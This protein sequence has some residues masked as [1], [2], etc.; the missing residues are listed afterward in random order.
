MPTVFI[1]DGGYS[2]YLHEIV[3]IGSVLWGFGT[4][5]DSSG[6]GSFNFPAAAKSTDGGATWALQN[7]A[8]APSNIDGS[9]ATG[10]FSLQVGQSGGIVTSNYNANT[11]L[12]W[13]AYIPNAQ[14]GSGVYTHGASIWVQ[15]FNPSTS[16]FSTAACYDSDSN[17]INALAS[18]L[19]WN[20]TTAYVIGNFVWAA[21]KIYKCILGNTNHTPPNATYWSERSWNNAVTYGA[22]EYVSESVL[23]YSC[24]FQSVAGGNINNDPQSGS[25]AWYPAINTAQLA[26]LFQTDDGNL[27]LAF[28]AADLNC[29]S[30]GTNPGHQTFNANNNHVWITAPTAPGSQ[31]N[32]NASGCTLLD[33]E[34]LTGTSSS[35]V[36]SVFIA[37]SLVNGN[38][39]YV[40]YE[41]EFDSGGAPLAT[42]P[43][44]HLAAIVGGTKTIYTVP[45][46]DSAQDGT[47]QTGVACKIYGSSAGQGSY[48]WTFARSA[49]L[50]G[51]YIDGGGNINMPV[52]YGTYSIATGAGSA[53]VKAMTGPPASW[54]FASVS[55]ALTWTS[56][57]NSHPETY[58]VNQNGKILTTWTTGSGVV[59]G[60]TYSAGWVTPFILTSPAGGT[61]FVYPIVISSGA[62]KLSIQQPISAFP[63]TTPLWIVPS[64]PTPSIACGTPPV[65]I[66]GVPYSYEFIATGG[67]PPYTL[68]AVT[69]GSLPAGLT[70]NPSTGV[71]SGT[72]TAAGASTYVITVTDSGSQTGS[73]SSC[74][75]TVVADSGQP[76][77][78]KAA[79]PSV[80]YTLTYTGLDSASSIVSNP[81]IH[82]SLSGKLVATDLGRKWCP[83][84]VP[85]NGASLMY[86]QAGVLQ[87][88]FLNGIKSGNVYTLDPSYLTDDDYGQIYPYYTTYG[89]PD[90]DTEEQK[91][92]GGGMKMV[93]YLQALIAGTGYLE[94]SIF[95]NTLAQLIVNGVQWSPRVC[96]ALDY[97]MQT[98]PI[99][100]TEWA[101]GQATAQRFFLQLASA[102]NPLGS[103]THPTTDNSFSISVLEAAIKANARYKIR[104]RY[105]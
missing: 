29:P 20:P 61:Y 92:L 71:A 73:T 40:F 33:G 31:F 78:W 24:V 75:I 63:A 105:P 51:G 32:T 9:S 88:V 4:R 84:Q 96:G 41:T 25:S 53:T 35:Y 60:S 2:G 6:N 70:L 68:F 11:G 42:F 79:S 1:Y 55:G 22:G 93:A 44:L 30:P 59:Y 77:Q 65:G 43:T 97:L 81:P 98:S 7:L 13:W 86:R 3:Q 80:I 90:R 36:V 95:C 45:C 15:S 16:L 104:G 8:A 89:I 83:W 47:S 102:P 64:L 17:A 50:G 48:G 74:S 38:D 67:T 103:T 87:P 52:L 72:P 100:N 34:F 76:C 46:G 19:I 62:I 14:T 57:S 5:D 39:L 56:G 49:S 28:L 12:V 101:G 23:Y 91:N 54:S 58:M 82:K 69:S 99:A 18:A 27:R 26:G 66:I 85:V 21:G 94:W 10:V 37:G